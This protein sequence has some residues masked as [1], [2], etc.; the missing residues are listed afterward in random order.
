[1]EIGTSRT[2]AKK[3]TNINIKTSDYQQIR[4]RRLGWGDY[5]AKFCSQVT[6][7]A[8]VL[9]LNQGFSSLEN[10]SRCLDAPAIVEELCPQ[11]GA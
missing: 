7:T 10:L 3:V 5:I 11:I 1:M 4:R 6:P 9:I 8:Q 2:M